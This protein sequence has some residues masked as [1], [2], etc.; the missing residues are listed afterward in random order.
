MHEYSSKMHAILM[1]KGIPTQ[2]PRPLNLGEHLVHKMEEGEEEEG[3][4]LWWSLDITKGNMKKTS[5]VLMKWLH[6]RSHVE[7]EVT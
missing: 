6:I 3:E 1:L 7:Q 4:S 2:E 5:T